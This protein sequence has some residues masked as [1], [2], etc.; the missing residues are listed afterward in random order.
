MYYTYVLRSESNVSQLYFGS[1]SNLK[2]RLAAHNAGQS[3][4]TA[5]YKPWAVVWYGSFESKELALAF[6][7]YL[8]TAS[9]K[10]FLRKHLLPQNL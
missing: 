1:T 7:K 2:E 3:P 10:A 9:G 6:E 4:H 5:K 8:K